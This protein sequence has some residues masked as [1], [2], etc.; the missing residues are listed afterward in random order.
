VQGGP[1]GRA[2]AQKGMTVKQRL[3]QH[4]RQIAA[5][6]KLMTVGMRMLNR[7]ELQID[8]NQKQIRD[9]IA[10]QRRTDATLRQFLDGMKRGNGHAK[11]KLD[12]Q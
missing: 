12:V 5:I 10:A 4:D 7:V 3:D 2:G 9:L 1:G 8:Q 6:R 11:T